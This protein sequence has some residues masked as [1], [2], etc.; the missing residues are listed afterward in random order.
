MKSKVVSIQRRIGAGKEEKNQMPLIECRK[1]LNNDGNRFSDN[2]IMEIRDF[3]SRLADIFIDHYSYSENQQTKVINLE[4]SKRS[5][6]D[7]SNYLRAG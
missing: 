6:Y 2:D 7:E 5:H 1:I 3:I 4:E